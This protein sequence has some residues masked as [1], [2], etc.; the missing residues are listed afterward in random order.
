MFSQTC[1]YALKIMIYLVS[2]QEEGK[3]AGLKDIAEAIASPEAFTA[4]ILQQLV[5]N[6]LLQ[7][8]R[9]PNG[10][11][12]LQ[13]DSITLKEIVKVIDGEGILVN[14]ILG[15]DTCSGKKPCPVHDKFSAVR[16]HLSGILTSTKL[17]DLKGGII[18]GNQF[19]KN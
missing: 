5:R 16:D 6:K 4:K 12:A 1:E 8:S 18:K 19:L 7:S 13:D 2:V 11:F 14:C 15:L 10:G 3:R 17:S 9:G